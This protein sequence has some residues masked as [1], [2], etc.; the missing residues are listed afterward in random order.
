MIVKAT[1]FQNDAR[2]PLKYVDVE[3]ENIR[4]QRLKGEPQKEGIL[5]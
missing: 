3:I 2:E 5:C 1:Y 4:R